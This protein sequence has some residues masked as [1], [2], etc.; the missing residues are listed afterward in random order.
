MFAPPR[1]RSSRNPAMK[2]KKPAPETKKHWVPEGSLAGFF[3]RRHLALESACEADFSWKLMCGAGPGDLGGS[4][5][6]ASAENPGKTGPKI[7]SQ[8]AFS[9]GRQKGW[10]SRGGFSDLM[11]NPSFWGSGRPREAQ[12][13]FKK[14]CP[15]PF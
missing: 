7:S 5:V 15:L 3:L 6:S 13:P 4:R 12:K 1:K 10:F 8:T 2:H 14:V 11:E 9:R